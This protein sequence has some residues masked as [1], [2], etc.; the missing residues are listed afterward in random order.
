MVRPQE[1]I[2]ATI[3]TLQESSNIPDAAN[4]VDNTPDISTQSIKLPV[5]EV[6]IGPQRILADENTDFIGTKTDNN[7]R[8][9]GR[10]Y[11]SLYTLELYVVTYTAQGSKYSARDISD[12]IRDELYAYD[13]SGP[14][15]TL[16]HPENGP[17]DEVWRFDIIEGVHTDD[18]NTNPTLR[19][20]QQDVL[21]S[22]SEQYVTT[23]VED[24][25][26]G[27]DLDV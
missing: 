22:A 17:V 20:W 27:I 7:G 13:T 2:E 21:V 26:A 5:I 6:S 14:N 12:S 19:R 9:I 18:L 1:I 25:A 4:Y 8:E 16:V 10:I 15:E 3:F 24:P 11:E 23:D